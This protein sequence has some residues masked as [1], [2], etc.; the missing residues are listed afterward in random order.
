[1]HDNGGGQFKNVHF[2]AALAGIGGFVLALV[3]FLK[4][5]DDDG[6]TYR[7]TPPVTVTTRVEAPAAVTTEPTTTSS[8]TSDVPPPPPPPPIPT[9][10]D[11]ITITVETLQGRKLGPNFFAFDGNLDFGLGYAYTATAGGVA[12][13]DESCQI[14]MQVTGPE[15]FPAQRTAECSRRVGSPFNG[16]INSERITVPGEYTITVTDELTGTTGTARFTLT[17]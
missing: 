7:S 13:K 4:S 14:I 2:W 15:W 11:A 6:P 1:M 17:R 3:V 5:C 10:V 16:G 8:T 12:V 9:R